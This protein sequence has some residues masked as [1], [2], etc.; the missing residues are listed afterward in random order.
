MNQVNEVNN[1]PEAEPVEPEASEPGRKCELDLIL[2]IPLNI[3]VELGQ[4]KISQ[5]N[6]YIYLDLGNSAYTTVGDL[7]DAFN[8]CGFDINAS[9]NDSGTGIQIESTSTTTTLKIEDMGED[10]TAHDMGIFGSTDILGS[11]MILVDALKNDDRDVIGQIIGN[12]D[13]GLQ[14]VLN[15]RASVGAKVIRLET[16]DSRLSDM[17]YNFTKLL[18]EVEDADL[19]K[20]VTDLATQENSY[21][22]ALIAASKIIQPSLLNFLE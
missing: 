14:D 2:D 10:G 6:Q 20:L 19:T 18:S 1:A 15:Q 16:T 13:A 4:V 8:N 17:Q 9:I 12:L 21:Q 5:G 3:R 22:S 7:I 11:M